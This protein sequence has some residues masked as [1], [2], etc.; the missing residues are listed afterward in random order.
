[1]IADKELGGMQLYADKAWDSDFV[2]GYKVQGIP[3]FILI[4]PNGNV[5]NA[6]APRQTVH[7]KKSELLSSLFLYIINLYF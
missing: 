2:K 1:M 7:N 3:R 5:V 6:D 4:D